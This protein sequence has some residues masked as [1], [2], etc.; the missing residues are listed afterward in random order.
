MAIGCPLLASNG[1]ETIYVTTTD[2]AQ[3]QPWARHTAACRRFKGP[4][5][6]LGGAGS[7][8][9]DTAA[10]LERDAW[11]DIFPDSDFLNGETNAKGHEII[12]TYGVLNTSK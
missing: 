6:D 8:P 4:G 11:L 12:V 1:K 10:G 3:D 2:M 5:P 7:T 9:R